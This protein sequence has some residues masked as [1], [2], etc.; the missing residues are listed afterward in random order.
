MTNHI[1]VKND[2]RDPDNVDN[3]LR[4]RGG[5]KHEIITSI[6]HERH[7]LHVILV[8]F[9]FTEY[10][11]P[12]SNIRKVLLRLSG[13]LRIPKYGYQYSEFF[14]CSVQIQKCGHSFVAHF[15]CWLWFSAR[16]REK[17]QWKGMVAVFC[18]NERKENNKVRERRAHNRS[19]VF[20]VTCTSVHACRPASPN[21]PQVAMNR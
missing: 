5:T 15:Y 4:D 11:I 14:S 10:S 20:C 12:P 2:S 18:S 21:T 3:T 1:E 19:L 16:T 8:C 6:I 17:A 13:V 7:S 9:C